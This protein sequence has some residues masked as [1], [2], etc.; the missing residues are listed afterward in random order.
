M[1]AGPLFQAR[2]G[3]RARATVD[4]WA[5]PSQCGLICQARANRECWNSETTVAGQIAMRVHRLQPGYRSLRA[6]IGSV[7]AKKDRTAQDTC[8]IDQHHLVGNGVSAKR[9]TMIGPRPTTTGW[10]GKSR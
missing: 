2:S 3:S 7:R 9:Q 5:F 10:L 6:V 8:A 4:H 1:A